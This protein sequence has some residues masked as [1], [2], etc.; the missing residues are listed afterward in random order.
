M[1]LFCLVSWAEPDVDFDGSVPDDCFLLFCFF[2]VFFFLFTLHLY[3]S[4][5][6]TTQFVALHVLE[7]FVNI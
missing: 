2:V 1:F 6:M 7:M 5:H 4:Q 3:I